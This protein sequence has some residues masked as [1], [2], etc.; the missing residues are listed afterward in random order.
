MI[1]DLRNQGMSISDIARELQMD[2]KTIR[3]YIEA[4][5]APRPAKRKKTKSKLDPFK[6]Y[7][8]QRMIEDQVW[9][10][11]KLLE[12]IKAKGYD[13]GKT[14]LKD[15]IKPYREAGKKKYTVRYETAPGEQMQMD[16]K[17]VGFVTIDGKRRKLSLFVV[18]LG[19]SRMKYAWFTFTQDQEHVMEG[20]LRAFD[21]FGGRPRSILFDN[22]KTVVHGRDQGR[23]IWNERFY[24]FAT[25][26][27]F[28]PKACRP[29]RAQTKGKVER[30]I[31]Y[32]QNHFLQGRDM[33]SLDTLNNQLLRW[34]DQTGNRKVHQTTG[35]SPQ[36]RWAEEKLEPVYALPRY[37]TSYH[38][39]RKCHWDGSLSYKG[40]R[41]LLPSTYAGQDILIKEALDGK[42]SFYHQGQTISY[43]PRSDVLSFSNEIIKKKQTDLADHPPSVS[44]HVDTRPLSFYDT[45]SKGEK[46]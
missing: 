36:E 5:S 13:G 7:L 27:G 42:L 25:H 23:V 26:Y 10:A 4:P 32:I 16:W 21:Y 22:M 46:A 38:T 2:R 29:Y 20:L 6:D 12:E 9:N 34:L 31:Q 44:V 14:I 1:K 11:V 3:K 35:V 37:D 40:R 24:A 17:E 39:Y 41:H 8:H 18:I 45:F 43:S 15:Y 28:V 30:A 19:Y 33:T